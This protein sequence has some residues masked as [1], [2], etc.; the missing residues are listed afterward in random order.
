MIT[1]LISHS[2]KAFTFCLIGFQVQSQIHY[3][4]SENNEKVSTF[5]IGF[6]NKISF[7]LIEG[8]SEFKSSNAIITANFDDPNSFVVYTTS[9]DS[10]DLQWKSIHS[11]S[12]EEFEKHVK[13]PVTTLPKAELCL[14]ESRNGLKVNLSNLTLNYCYPEGT[15]EVFKPAIKPEKWVVSIEGA[16]RNYA[17]SGEELTPEAISAIKKAK[18]KK[19]I[20]ISTITSETKVINSTFIK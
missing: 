7:N 17:G 8:V 13:F 14:G 9:K 15:P 20:T 19:I 5:Y 18:S 16:K 2:F 11:Q 6:E 12:G 4:E 10:V 3:T 1:N